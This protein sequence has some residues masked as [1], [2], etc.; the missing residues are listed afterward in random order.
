VRP[1]ERDRDQVETIPVSIREF[2]SRPAFA[3]GVADVRAGQRPRREVEAWTDTNQQWA[4][5]RGRQFGVL[6]P[7]TMPLRIGGKLNREAVR[8]FERF[9]DVIL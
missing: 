2:M 3:L 8:L 1:E 7:R 5:E 6:A 9:N 4:Y